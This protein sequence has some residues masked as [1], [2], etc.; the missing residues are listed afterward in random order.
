[1][2]KTVGLGKKCADKTREQAQQYHIDHHA[3]FGKRVA[4]P[5]GMVRYVGYYPQS[6]TNMAGEAIDIPWDFIVPESFT[7]EFFNNI[8]QW[9]ENDPDGQEITIDE[10]RFCD[11]SAGVMMVCD[12]NEIVPDSGRE[13]INI[14]F[15]AKRAKG[16][17]PRDH[18]EKHRTLIGPWA[19]KVYGEALLD[20][21]AYYIHEAYN[22]KTGLM[23]EAPYDVMVQARFDPAVMG[24]MAA[25]MARPDV[26]ELLQEEAKFM[27]TAT[28]VSMVCR[29]QPYIL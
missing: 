11:R 10:A 17:E 15:G 26:I 3:P 19:K 21:R 8:E 23:P 4:Q 27:D 6:A 2:I 24:D 9:R 14:F 7:D 18:H 16:L 5:L 20:Y 22:L 12:D 29:Y 28:L 1:M 25:W 13:G